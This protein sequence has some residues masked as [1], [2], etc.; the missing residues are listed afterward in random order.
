MLIKFNELLDILN[1]QISKLEES[2]ST[3]KHK[4][5]DA[6]ESVMRDLESK[7]AQKSHQNHFTPQEML[8]LNFIERKFMMNYLSFDSVVQ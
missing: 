6:L 1:E 2:F 8:K 5:V 3:F 4:I 7:K